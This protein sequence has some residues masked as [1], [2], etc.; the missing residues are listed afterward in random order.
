MQEKLTMQD[1]QQFKECTFSP[2][3]SPY[4][5]P[6]IAHCFLTFF[7]KAKSL[8]RDPPSRTA[9]QVL[10]ERELKLKKVRCC[11]IHNY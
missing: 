10:E 8:H 4:V 9:K 3:I 6:S 7:I 2:E 1:E 11:I 5:R